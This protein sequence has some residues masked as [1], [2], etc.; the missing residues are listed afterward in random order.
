M[1]K[2]KER[3]KNVEHQVYYANTA[4]GVQVINND[5]ITRSEALARDDADQW[6]I[7]ESEEMNSLKKNNTWTLT[8]LPDG[9]QPVGCKWV[10]KIKYDK[11][12]HIN[13]YKARLVAKGF[14]QKYGIDYD[15]TF[16]PVA[17]FSSIR[18]LLA[19]GA[20]FDLE[21]HQ[22]DVKTAFFNGDIDTEIF[23][24]Q[25]DGYQ[26]KGKEH[27]VCRLNKSIYGLKQAGRAW[28]EKINHELLNLGMKQS[29][30]D[31]CIYTKITNS[32]ILIIALYVDDLLILT[33]SLMEMNKIKEQL[34][35]RFEMKDLGEAKFILGIEIV[36][37][38]M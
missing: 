26:E 1:K 36:K 6:I 4:V 23:M 35:S 17:R 29:Q 27:L 13:K 21:I 5:P 30:S 9:R 8:E 10:Y 38:R 2:L 31:N 34:T 11:D 3:R 28:Y 15:E 7:A 24:K 20:Q 14:T 37:E 25:P 18:A 12:G 32:E 22:M 16:A 19:M 33:K